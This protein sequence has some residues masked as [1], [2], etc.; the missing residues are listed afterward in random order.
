MNKYFDWTGRCEYAGN[1]AYDFYRRHPLQRWVPYGLVAVMIAVA[2]YAW[3]SSGFHPQMLTGM[4][5][6]ALL[7]AFVV[8]WV[9]RR[10]RLVFAPD[11]LDID[12]FNDSLS[13]RQ[14]IPYAHIRGIQFI[15]K[16]NWATFQR[17]TLMQIALHDN[18]SLELVL[19]PETAKEIND[20][21]SGIL[22]ERGLLEK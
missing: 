21:L 11:T 15:T 2:I 5:V 1:P 8:F 18:K 4:G 14:R 19:S 6:T 20:L 3:V 13:V 17:Q 10:R 7:C 12:W 9:T 16:R 22:R